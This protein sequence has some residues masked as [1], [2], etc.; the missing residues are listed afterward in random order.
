MAQVDVKW[1]T[2]D[3]EFDATADA[4]GTPPE[5][6]ETP[7]AVTDANDSV[8]SETV[9]SPT[10]TAPEVETSETDTGDTSGSDAE[11][12][13]AETEE[14]PEAET[15]KEQSEAAPE[16]PEESASDPDPVDTA[17]EPP[18]EPE[19]SPE[20]KVVTETTPDDE[21]PQQTPTV[22]TGG[23]HVGRTV[24]IGVLVLIIA[25]LGL[26]AWTLHSDKNNLQKQ[27]S[28]L[29]ANPQDEVKKQA[30]EIVNKVSK[31]TT[32]P[33]GETPTIANVTDAAAAK[34]QSAF[35]ADA[36]NG[37]KVLVYVNGGQAILYRPSTNKII[38]VG[39]LTNGSTANTKSSTST[40]STSTSSNST[41]IQ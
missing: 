35:F 17:S 40:S 19:T 29:K 8:G 34:K 5:N 26:Y 23:H 20:P 2:E 39:P 11:A 12:D 10:S 27:V 1:P 28:Q 22:G 37:D 24:L 18:S 33:K 13:A 9:I 41:K 31:L 30:E 3:E 14:T 7:V 16:A 25:G 32:L 36:K 4:A 6:T 15:D 38:L 21:K